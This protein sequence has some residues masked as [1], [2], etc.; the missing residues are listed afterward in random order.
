MAGTIHI[1]KKEDLRHLPILDL[2]VIWLFI[3]CRR[4]VGECEVMGECEVIGECEVMG[5]NM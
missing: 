1:S 2:V 5:E 3:C 4:I